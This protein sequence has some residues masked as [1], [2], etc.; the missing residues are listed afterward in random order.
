[1]IDGIGQVDLLSIAESRGIKLSKVAAHE[2]HGACPRCGGRDRFSVKFALDR[3][4]TFCRQCHPERM[5][6][7]NFVQW[8]DGVTTAEAIRHLGLS[9]A[10]PAAPMTRS[11]PS[12]ARSTPTSDA[13][14]SP[15]PAQWQELVSSHL[16]RW[17]E[18]LFSYD[19]MSESVI[20]WLSARGIDGDMM[21]Q[22][23]IGLCDTS[24]WLDDSKA[25]WANRGIMIP[26]MFDGHLW[27][28][29]TR[30]F[31]LDIDADIAKEPEK[32]PDKY[33]VVGGAGEDKSALFGDGDALLGEYK[34]DSPQIRRVVICEGE[35]DC[36][37]LRSVK[38]STTAVVTTGSASVNP[39][40]GWIRLMT[41][42]PRDIVLLMDADG[43]GQSASKKWMSAIPSARIV[44]PPTKDVTDSW[45]ASALLFDGRDAWLRS[46]LGSI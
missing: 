12:P 2:Y 43:A 29:R 5:D 38:D 22:Y 26:H 40:A 36:M 46:W 17:R 16:R 27:R 11:S 30:R 14:Q 37:L 7:I 42:T 33:R 18:R 9:K 10:L 44:A 15:P 21:R 28:V 3:W 45:T 4:W 13:R 1:M 8:L 35:F 41:W 25:V 34:A 32:K 19:G 23:G 31:R 20:G 24:G 39:K 6:A